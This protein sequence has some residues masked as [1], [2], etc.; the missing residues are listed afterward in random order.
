MYAAGYIIRVYD[1]ARRESILTF[2][3]H[4]ETSS[5]SLLP[6]EKLV[7]SGGGEDGT[8]KAMLI[9]HFD[10]KKY[11]VDERQKINNIIFSKDGKSATILRND[12]I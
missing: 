1:I 2:P 12:S 6:N 10:M 4:L 3:M 5:C 8:I 9:P 11:L 7:F